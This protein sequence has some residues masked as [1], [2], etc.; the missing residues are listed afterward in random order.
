MNATELATKMLEWEK[1]KR[2][3]DTLA[4][5][6]EAE[7]LQ[8]GKTYNVGNVRATFAKGR[9]YT[10]YDW[11]P[12]EQMADPDVI[13]KFTTITTN[14]VTDWEKVAVECELAPIVN[15]KTGDPSVTVNLLV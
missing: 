1:L 4:A 2:Q 5:E 14:S 13:E 11:T 8:M 10:S 15:T 7:V 3:A 6:I 9:T 12:V